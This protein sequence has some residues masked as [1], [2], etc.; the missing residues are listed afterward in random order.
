MIVAERPFLHAAGLEFEHPV[1]GASL[2]FAS[3]L[4]A[5]L[6]GLLDGLVPDVVDSID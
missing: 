6:Q 1:T 2:V 3:P 5:D 4:P